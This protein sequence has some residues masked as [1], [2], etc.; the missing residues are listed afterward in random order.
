MYNTQ[1]DRPLYV[2][3]L[4][5]TLCNIEHRLHFLEAKE[6]MSFYKECLY[7]D[8]VK[9]VIN[10]MIAIDS[11]GGE[12]WI[13]TGRSEIVREETI[14][15][16]HKNTMFS[17]AELRRYP[18]TLIMRKDGDHTDDHVL[19]ER[20]LHGLSVEDRARLVCVFEDRKRVVNMWRSNG[21][22]CL[23]VAPGEF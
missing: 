5:G 13:L 21:I 18:H 2:F 4:D 20:W 19:K 11:S 9:A 7:D 16:L 22:V 15:W 14:D 23:Q 12:I 6:W 8:P 3:D 17:G 10:I 1:N